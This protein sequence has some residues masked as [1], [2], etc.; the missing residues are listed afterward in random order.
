LIGHGATV[1]EA[2]ALGSSDLQA[3]RANLH[4]ERP[5][6]RETAA[7]D[8]R[9]L[10]YGPSVIRM[11][12]K[13]G[14]PVSDLFRRVACA[15]AEALGSSWAFMTAVVV[16]VAW[17]A[18]GPFFGFSDT[19]Q[20]VINTGTTIVTFL[21]VFLI[22]NAQNRDAKALHLKLDELIHAVKEARNELIDVEDLTDEELADLHREFVRMR[23]RPSR[24]RTEPRSTN[25]RAAA[26]RRARAGA[27]SD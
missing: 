5:R 27:S 22:Q 7:S 1:A 21:M 16:V 17:A 12:T 11:A 10:C 15:S 26:R 4:P 23:K 3:A 25:G 6:P 9:G 2:L 24:A 20:L 14:T 13:R 19:W 8:R 18:S